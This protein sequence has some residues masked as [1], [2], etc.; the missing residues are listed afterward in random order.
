MRHPARGFTLIE[1]MIVVTVL[2]ILA[3]FA[4]PSYQS[5]VMRSN[6]AIAK[7]AVMEIS[8]K[9][10][11]WYVDR[12]QYATTLQALGYPGTAGNPV[13]LGRD[14]KAS[15]TLTGDAAFSLN[16]SSASATAYTVV[17]T[18]INRQTKDTECLSLRVDNLGNRTCTGSGA[19]T[20]SC[21]R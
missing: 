21:W 5:Y 16:L 11:S 4:L 19:T 3:A 10:E 17:A 8:S 2:A 20:N 6:R 15:A 12:K 7:T 18:A 14:G 1:L 13:Y 9:E